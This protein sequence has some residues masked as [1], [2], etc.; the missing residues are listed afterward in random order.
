[1]CGIAGLFVKNEGRDTLSDVINKM[2][3]SL[4]HRGPDDYGSFVHENFAMG[5]RRLSIIDIEGG[6]Q[7]IF[8]NDGRYGIVYNGELYNYLEI[9]KDLTSQ[10]VVFQTD[11][12][13]EVVLKAYIKF[14]EKCLQSFNGMY[15]FAIFDKV[16]KEFFLARDRMGIKPLYYSFLSG[17]GFAFA[18]E[19]KALLEIPGFDR[20]ID[21]IAMQQYFTFEYIPEPRSI[22]KNVKKLSSACYLRFNP[23]KDLE[24][25]PYWEL[26]L[27][28]PEEN[29]WDLA[30]EKIRALLRSSVKYRL[31]SDVPVGLFLSGG[32]DSSI[33]ASEFKECLSNDDAASF[34]VGFDNKSYD[35]L[36][37][38]RMMAEHAGIKH[39]HE[40]LD[41]NRVLELLPEIISQFDEPLADASIIPTYFLSK[42]TQKSVK[43]ALSGDGGDELFLGYETHRA[44]QLARFFKILPEGFYKPFLNFLNVIPI[45]D[46]KVSFEFKLRKFFSVIGYPSDIVNIL[47]RGGLFSRNAGESFFIK[48][49]RV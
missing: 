40:C 1:M 47:W 23:G 39:E 46:N 13:T 12:D 11:T 27:H 30:N 48:K 14:G 3:Q 19:L 7:P 38:A 41:E 15:A 25:R 29:N 9:K 6:H 17:K 26:D 8:S 4:V 35:E 18:S 43:V 37:F 32:I 42:F 16:K 22:Y 5:M 44:H 20:N 34:S 24:L 21:S 10:G 33:I 28:S 45:S 36:G 49:C 31:V 2:C